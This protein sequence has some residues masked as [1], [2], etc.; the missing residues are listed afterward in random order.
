MSVIK[1]P[2]VGYSP[3]PG[4]SGLP[5][6]PSKEVL[7]EWPGINIGE[8]P[9]VR[10]VYRGLREVL[11]SAFTVPRP[12]KAAGK[13]R[14]PPEPPEPPSSAP[15][16]GAYA[17]D[18]YRSGDGVVDELIRSY[19][20]VDPKLLK[21]AVEYANDAVDREISAA[22]IRHEYV[23]RRAIREK[24]GDSDAV[25]TE[26]E[27]DSGNRYIWTARGLSPLTTV[28]AK[29]HE[30]VGARKSR[31]GYD[32]ARMEPEIYESGRRLAK[33]YINDALRELL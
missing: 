6:V 1:G 13:D 2:G 32:H 22:G 7:A 10:L 30:L 15:E 14:P 25:A 26:F 21:T 24:T 11:N 19:K 29:V 16:A 27:G 12:G 28:A 9:G 18:G 17:M 4:M 8:I 31:E 23:S 3:L 5:V 33:E 20:G